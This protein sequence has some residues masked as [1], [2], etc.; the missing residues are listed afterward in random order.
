MGNE[1]AREL[2]MMRET[3][4]RMGGG[5]VGSGENSREKKSKREQ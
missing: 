2:E 5:G 1:R 4:G 3:R